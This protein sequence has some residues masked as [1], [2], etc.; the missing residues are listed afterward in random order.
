MKNLKEAKWIW[1]RDWSPLH[2]EDPQQIFFRKSIQINKAKT[3]TVQISADTRYKLYI[4]DRLVEVGPSKGD[5]QIWFLDTIDITGYLNEGINVFAIKIL[6]YPMIHSKGNYAMFRTEQ[7]G[8]YFSCSILE[9]TNRQVDRK[10]EFI[11]DSSW[12]TYIDP[13]FSI[14]SESDIFAPLQIY[15]NIQGNSETHTWMNEGYDDDFWNYAEEYEEFAISRQVSPG[16]LTPRTI[17]FMYRKDRKF[18]NIVTIRKGKSPKI[19]WENLINGQDSI[20][21]SPNSTSIVEISA[22]EEMTGYLHLEFAKGKNSKIRILQSESYVQEE[23]TSTNGMPIPVKTDR[24]D[25]IN[26]HLDGFT[27]NYIVGGFGTKKITER[28]DPFWLRTFRFIQL[29]ITTSDEELIFS[30]FDYTETGYPLA[31]KTAIETSDKSLN[32]IWAISERT[33]KRCMHETYEDCPFYEQLQYAMD[34]RS[35]IL[36]TYAISADDRLARKCMD[37]FKRSQRYDGLLNCS[38][39]CFGPN[40]IPTFSIYYILMLHDH[41]MY[42]GDKKLIEEHFPT[43]VSIL[44]FFNRNLDNKKYVKKIGGLNIIDRFWSFTDW[45]TE[46]NKTSGVPEATLNGPITMESLIYI[47]GLQKAAE[48]AE[49]IGLSDKSKIFKKRAEQVQ[50]AVRK[51]CIGDNLLLK[52]GPFSNSYSQ[53]TQVFAI[54][55]N[56][57]SKEQGQKNLLETIKNKSDYAQCSVAMAFYLFRAMEQ[58]DL[59]EHTNEYWDIWRRMVKKNATTCVEAEDGDR[60]D[61]HA[62][63]ALILY[64]LPAITLGV[65]P[66]QPGF[67]EIEINPNPG[68]MDWAKG[69]VITPKGDVTVEWTKNDGK[70]DVQ[71]TVPQGISVKLSK[72]TASYQK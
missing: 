19:D 1:V 66:T 45:T 3:G 30:R 18:N 60:S 32:D 20:V 7:P 71:Y 5:N 13:N 24:E 9:E 57:L 16:N 70:I 62:W 67:S 39:P 22:G 61:C 51:Y 58:V 47:F 40:V 52:D 42:F 65:K 34:S 68:Y 10:I 17:P 4:N 23:M 49:Y 15:E 35:Q 8:L 63:G 69:T 54:L 6:R 12:K 11:S 59:Y 25:H 38:Y 26:G 27:D 48:L 46:W 53:H 14:V 44:S 55:T 36:Y 41:M 31:V 50:D 33:L 29:E 37:D 56:T 28:Y 43:I 2:K 72:D 21:L 64:E